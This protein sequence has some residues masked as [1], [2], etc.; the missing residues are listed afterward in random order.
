MVLRLP[1]SNRLTRTLK[2]MRS[3]LR[4]GVAILGYHRVHTASPDPLELS[5]H[6]DR[7]EA[8]L[9]VIKRLA[10]PTSLTDAIAALEQGIVLPRAVVMT[11]DDGYVDNLHTV[12]PLLERYEVPATV[13]VTSGNR[14]G[15]FWWDALARA[16]RPGGQVDIHQMAAHFQTLDDAARE[17]ALR[18]IT[19]SGTP[20]NGQPVHRTLTEAELR[21]LAASPWIEIGA[22]TVTHRSLPQL[23][24]R[25]QH[26]EIAGSRNVLEQLID[27]PV[28]TFAYPHGR[29]TDETIALVRQAGYRAACTSVLDVARPRSTLFALPRLWAPDCSGPEFEGWLRGWLHVD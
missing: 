2:R 3:R 25:Q 10:R 1:G 15:E 7:F 22:H 29:L 4:P 28:T 19:T 16:F 20:A 12:L 5:V 13:F 8:Q 27:R 6:P 9:A 17:R 14:G 21:E 26:D 24:A 11:F 23:D 18:E